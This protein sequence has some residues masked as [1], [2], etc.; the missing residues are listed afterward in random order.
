MINKVEN[1]ENFF[2]QSVIERYINYH[3]LP[4]VQS[5]KSKYKKKSFLKTQ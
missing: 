4:L 2:K 5:V 1:E 3:L